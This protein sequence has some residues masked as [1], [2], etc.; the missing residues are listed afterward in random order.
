MNTDYG[1]DK[2]MQMVTF[3]DLPIWGAFK[4]L[5]LKHEVAHEYDGEG[6]GDYPFDLSGRKVV[7]LYVNDDGVL[8]VEVE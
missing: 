2:E 7:G 3:G 5:D 8:T 4:V 1:S 6:H